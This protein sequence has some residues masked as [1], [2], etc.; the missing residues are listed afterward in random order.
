MKEK[1]LSPTLGLWAVLMGSFFLISPMLAVVDV[2]PDFIGYALILFG[3]SRFADMNDKIE[4]AAKLFRRLMI[5]GLVR[6]GAI[7]FIYGVSSPVEQPVLQLLCS[8]V[9][10]VLECMTL[11]PAWKKLSG[12]LLYLSSRHGGEV[13]F[14]T[15][16]AGKR[17]GSS[18]TLL[19]RTT[20][21][22]IV[23]LV[24]REVLATLPEFTVLTSEKG[25]MEAG[26][27][28]AIYDY[29][30][31]M[32]ET[33]AVIV[34]VW[35]VIWLVRFLR[36]GF[37]LG[38]DEIF[39]TAMREKY[40]QEVLTRPE[41]FARRAVK[42]AMILMCIGMCFSVDFFLADLHTTPICVTPDFI[43]GILLTVGLLMMRKY[44]DKRRL[45]S[46][47]AV[48]SVYTLL[49]VAEWILPLSWMDIRKLHNAPYL[50]ERWTWAIIFSGV[51]ALLSVGALLLLMG[52]LFNVID[53]YTGFSVTAHDSA[54][55][56][57]RVAEIHRSLKRRLW[58]AFGLGVVTA[59]SS[60][61]SVVVLP[62]S[63]YSLWELWGTVD[64]LL[65]IICAVMFILAVMEIFEQ[66]DYKY[67]LSR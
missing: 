50:Y 4:D 12:G 16:Y 66:I 15:S 38:K 34:L 46:A 58:V 22:T 26:E 10:G 47:T 35:G 62:F 18:K 55:P 53:R 43:M 28:L 57:L 20:H 36:F 11:I 9:L 27:G 31:F 56:N 42:R 32:R 25:G 60:V 17:N 54:S 30:S 3:V 13:V 29:I 67:M 21:A 19:E 7:V 59:A 52:V 64:I 51:M 6:M 24:A 8:F 48:T 5:L 1:R 44:A 45:I 41:L 61:V 14:A 37:Y 49:A 65:P 33:C 40:S 23:F 63:E 2:L 39:L